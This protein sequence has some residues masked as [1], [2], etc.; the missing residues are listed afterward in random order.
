MALSCIDNI[1]NIL[2]RRQEKRA[3][4]LSMPQWQQN[5]RTQVEIRADEKELS[6]LFIEVNKASARLTSIIQ[7]QTISLADINKIQEHLRNRS[8]FFA[9]LPCYYYD[10][11]HH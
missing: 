4:I 6:D 8:Q 3:Q 5:I 10:V 11:K 9:T 1:Y 7:D 2:Q